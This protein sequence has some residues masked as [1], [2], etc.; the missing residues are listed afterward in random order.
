[1]NAKII[2][3]PLLLALLLCLGILLNE[4]CSP[5]QYDFA[6]INQIDTMCD[7][8]IDTMEVYKSRTD[9]HGQRIY[10]ECQSFMMLLRADRDY[11]LN[12]PEYLEI[13]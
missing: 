12:H 8:Y 10:A 7:K 9:F 4:G 13:K 6:R 2:L 1:M 3:F 5:K 11:L